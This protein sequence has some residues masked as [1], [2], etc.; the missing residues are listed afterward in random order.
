MKRDATTHRTADLHHTATISN[1]IIM[2]KDLFSRTLDDKRQLVVTYIVSLN[3][4]QAMT[5]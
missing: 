3:A 1:D 2:L 5:R 4:R